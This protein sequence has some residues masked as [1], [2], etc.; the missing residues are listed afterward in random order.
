MRT[1]RMVLAALCVVTLCGILAAG[2][3]PFNPY[4]KNEVSWLPNQNGLSF[5]DYGTLFSSG[6][7]H[8]TN[9]PTDKSC[10]L[11]IWLQPGLA[12]DSNN[13]LA[14]YSRED[15]LQFSIGQTGD[16]LFMRRGIEDEKHHL[17]HPVIIVNHVFRKDQKLFISIRS[18]GQVADVYLNGVQATTSKD[19]RLT[20]GAFAGRLV[21]G[22]SP[23]E[24]NSWS[25]DI[26]GI[27]IYRK[28][29]SLL[30]IQQHSGA[31]IDSGNV[32]IAEDNSPLGVYL[33]NE[34]VGS[35]VH[36]KVLSEPDLYIPEHYTILAPPFLELPWK[37][38]R[39]NWDYGKDVLENIAA[40]IPL[41]FL[42]CAYFSSL[43]IKWAVPGAIILGGVVSLTIEVLQVFLPMRDS[44]ITDIIT[45][46][47]GT[48][49]GALFYC[50]KPVRTLFIKVG[51]PE[52]Q[53]EAPRRA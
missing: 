48:A 18:D 1:Y 29:L 36:N 44:G 11:E 40:F 42:F 17:R 28:A 50:W 51:V 41:G 25:G 27:A 12:N 7:F 49:A 53:A 43:R 39:R 35:V 33:F 23:I 26:W 19:F 34:R 9:S 2:L 10:S 45:N 3:W 4:P 20:S 22:N 15:P 13:I 8:S 24:N 47:T 14:F 5:G 37:E 52:K 32:E 38:F 16:S 31:W 46:T 6:E 21:V 30:E